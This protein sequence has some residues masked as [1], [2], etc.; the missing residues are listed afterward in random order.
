[1][2]G[3]MDAN[4]QQTFLEKASYKPMARVCDFSLAGQKWQ[5]QRAAKGKGKGKAQGLGPTPGKDDDGF[6]LVD[7]RT[8]PNKT[9]GKGRPFGKSKGKGR[10]IAINYQEGI[11]G[12]K[13]KPFFTANQN[14][15]KGK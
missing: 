7:T 5:E 2:E 13:Q 15:G 3:R 9:Q 6:A 1:M 14:Q 11:L 4:K 12:Q 8:L 10:G